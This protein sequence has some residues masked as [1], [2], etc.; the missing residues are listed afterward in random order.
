MQFGQRKTKQVAPFADRSESRGLLY[1][2]A[3]LDAAQHLAQRIRIV[4]FDS[5]YTVCSKAE[6][7][8]DG[9]GHRDRLRKSCDV[10]QRLCP[11]QKSY[12]RGAIGECRDIRLQAWLRHLVDG[13]RRSEEH[14]S[15][16]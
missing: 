10:V 11:Q 9:I 12:I 7:G 5:G 8:E 15:E 3:G 13:E 4:G 6:T 14:T 1:G 16:L 2:Y